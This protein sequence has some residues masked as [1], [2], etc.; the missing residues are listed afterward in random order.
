MKKPRVAFFLSF[1]LPGAGLAYLG[2][3]GWATLN[4]AA[5]LGLGFTLA[6][7]VSSD[8]ANVL[9]IGLGAASGALAMTVAQSMQ[10]KS[11]ARDVAPAT[12]GAE[13][14]P[15]I[16]TACGASVTTSKFCGE[17]GSPLPA[18]NQCPGCGSVLDAPYRFCTE[19]GHP[20]A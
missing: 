16:C 6:S 9:G 17:C 2:K 4:F 13:A 8:A 1:L 19:C 15:R 3:W 5:V 11:N 12:A 7:S 20:M 18:V 14:Q 10:A